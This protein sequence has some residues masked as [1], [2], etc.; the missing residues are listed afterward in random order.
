MDENELE[1]LLSE[2][3][4]STVSGSRTFQIK[5]VIYCLQYTAHGENI[6][7][8][9]NGIPGPKISNWNVFQNW[10]KELQQY[11]THHKNQSIEGFTLALRDQNKHLWESVVSELE[12]MNFEP[13]Y[14]AYLY[15]LN[16]ILAVCQSDSSCTP[17]ME[18]I[19]EELANKYNTSKW[20]IKLSI[21]TY[22][23]RTY[24]RYLYQGDEYK[25]G[26]F[27]TYCNEDENIPIDTFIHNIA[28]K[29]KGGI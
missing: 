9:V 24:C 17:D 25:S 18:T 11:I 29:I 19:Y 10:I 7:V 1:N 23:R 14:K 21:Q 20:N 3:H 28:F 26:L 22:L 12:K 15:L 8:K 2:I 13:Q 27:L 5:N 4:S 6:N 16:A